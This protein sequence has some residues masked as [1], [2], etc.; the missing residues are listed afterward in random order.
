MTAFYERCF[1]L[2]G[3]VLVKA[4]V[5]VAV[6]DPPGRRD[7]TPLKLVF[8]VASIAESGATVL[9]AGG[10]VEDEPWEWEDHRRCDFLDPEGNVGQ[11]REPR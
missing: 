10:R 2:D 4:G 8:D 6:A 3:L 11:L 5:V 7:A 1:G 9:A